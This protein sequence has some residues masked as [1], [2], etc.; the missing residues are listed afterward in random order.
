MDQIRYNNTSTSRT[1]ALA[2]VLTLDERRAVVPPE[3]ITLTLLYRPCDFYVIRRV[4]PA[5]L[6]IKAR[7]KARRGEP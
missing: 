3:V 6:R 2:L 1:L 4:N 5:G 7:L